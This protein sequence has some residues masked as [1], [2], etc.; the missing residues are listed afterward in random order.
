MRGDGTSRGGF[1]FTRCGRYVRVTRFLAEDS[2]ERAYASRARALRRNA[3][4][5]ARVRLILRLWREES[6][7]GEQLK[8]EE[9][10]ESET[11][12]F[13]VL[14]ISLLCKRSLNGRTRVLLDR[15]FETICK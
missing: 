13:H 1:P 9:N 15:L 3:D 14:G 12:R 6:R 7:G 4:E 5:I 10:A 2:A 11:S 8:G